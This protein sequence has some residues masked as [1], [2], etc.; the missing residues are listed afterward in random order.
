M[1]IFALGRLEF[2]ELFPHQEEDVRKQLIEAKT[3]LAHQRAR[4]S[5][6]GIQES[7]LRRQAEKDLATP[8][9][10]QQ[11]GL[12]RA[13]TR[14]SISLPC[15]A[16]S[17]NCSTRRRSGSKFTVEQIELRDPGSQTRLFHG[18]AADA[19]AQTLPRRG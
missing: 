2:A 14:N 15:M 6:S 16:T 3:Y 9:A 11:P 8:Q 18:W 12:L 5:V 1:A 17:T 19:V 7:R 13:W 4:S 10:L